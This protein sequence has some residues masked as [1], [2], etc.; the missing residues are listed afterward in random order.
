MIGVQ[1]LERI[2]TKDSATIGEQCLERIQTKVSAIRLLQNVS[3]KQE[4]IQRIW[5]TSVVLFHFRTFDP[6]RCSI[7]NIMSNFAK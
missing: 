6:V 1:C 4:R 2:Q 3:T 7:C 5:P